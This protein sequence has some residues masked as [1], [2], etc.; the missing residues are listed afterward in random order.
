MKQILIITYNFPPRSGVGSVRL[1]GLAK[2]LPEFGWKPII[3]TATLPGEPDPR[4]EVIQTPYNDNLRF[5]KRKSELELNEIDQKQTRGFFFK[6]FL[7]NQ[8]L[9]KL[10]LFT[11]RFIY[12][13]LA[14]PDE[15]KGWYRSAVNSANELIKEKTIHAMISSFKPATSHIIASKIKGTWHIPWIADFRDLWTQNYNYHDY[16]TII[17]KS[18]ERHLEL[19][20]LSRAD[21]LTTV[22]EPLVDA[23]RKLHPNKPVYE[24]PNGFDPLEISTISSNE[25]TNDFTITYTG[26]LHG[27]KMDPSPLFKAIS[28]LISEGCLNPSD[29]KIRFYGIPER[30]LEV[31]TERYGVREI[32]KQY[33]YVSREES[34]KRQRESQILLLLNWS[35]IEGHGVYTGKLFEYLAAQR[36]ILYLGKSGGVI[37][38]ILN[39]TGAG[40]Y[41]PTADEIKGHI[42][43]CYS[44]YK[45]KGLVYYKGERTKIDKYSHREMARKFSDILSSLA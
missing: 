25:L 21:A 13:I 7:T 8:N 22:S 17:R 40:V 37:E 33:G 28:E 39:E 27:C 23:L 4:Y 44:E 30:C 34:L 36:P 6:R 43:N 2:Y 20:T 38:K 3:L 29:L 32:V 41:A 15:F 12:D 14:Y 11:L 45:S 5:L 10:K 24:I 1:E 42:R 19:K 31:L 26:T 35:H 9:S 18:F 16:H